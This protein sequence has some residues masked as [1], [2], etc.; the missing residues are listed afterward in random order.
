MFFAIFWPAFV[1]FGMVI[2]SLVADRLR[3]SFRHVRA[4]AFVSSKARPTGRGSEA[5]LG[6]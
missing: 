4:H 1:P 5:N 6:H 3:R 2:L